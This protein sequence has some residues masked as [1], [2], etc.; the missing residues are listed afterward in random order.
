MIESE[1]ETKVLEEKSSDLRKKI[2]R[3]G[4]KEKPPLLI[5]ARVYKHPERADYVRIREIEEADTG[6]FIRYQDL[7][8]TI[9]KSVF[10]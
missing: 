5:M 4:G 6:T 1:I 7:E 10:F 9:K 2:L 3:L 8:L